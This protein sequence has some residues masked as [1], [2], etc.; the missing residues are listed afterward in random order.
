M[1]EIDWNK[2]IKDKISGAEVSP[3]TDL[4]DGILSRTSR[5]RAVILWTSVA[6]PLVAAAASLAIVLAPG[7]TSVRPGPQA[8]PGLQGTD[9][10]LIADAGT[11]T[12][13]A[14]GG[15]QPADADRQ[16]GTETVAVATYQPVSDVQRQDKSDQLETASEQP[17]ISEQPTTAEHL[18][19]TEQPTTT[20]HPSAPEK[21]TEADVQLGDVQ[22]AEVQNNEVQQTEARQT[23][24]RQTEARQTGAQQTEV[25]NNEARQT[26]LQQTEVQNAGAHETEVQKTEVIRTPQTKQAVQTKPAAQAKPG[27]GNKPVRFVKKS[28]MEVHTYIAGLNANPRFMGKLYAAENFFADAS[29]GSATSAPEQGFVKTTTDPKERPVSQYSPEDISNYNFSKDSEN[30]NWTLP[31]K[32]EIGLSIPVYDRLFLETGL[33]YTNLQA[34]RM[35]KDNKITRVNMI[36]IPVGASYAFVDQDRFRVSAGAQFKAEK[37][38]GVPS[39]RKIQLSTGISASAAYRIA[40]PVYLYLA[41]EMSYYFKNTLPAVST[42]GYFTYYSAH[43]LSFTVRMGVSVDLGR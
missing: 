23:E 39:D 37:T 29:P 30:D 21:L 12:Q 32:A 1:T 3:D 40:G 26:E 41:P 28:G 31:V 8:Q 43:P 42:D 22:L 14:A 24:V 5:R 7:R 19:I 4:L 35:A 34:K 13:A 38:L 11:G 2:I 10:A 36:G 6:V 18:A 20:G 25:Q 33:V 9:I 17:S 16:S 27:T 15:R